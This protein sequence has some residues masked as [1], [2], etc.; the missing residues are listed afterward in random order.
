MDLPRNWE[1]ASPINE[2]LSIELQLVMFDRVRAFLVLHH[3]PASPTVY[4]LLWRYLT[5]NHHAL[6]YDVDVAMA[7]FSFDAAKAAALHKRHC[8]MIAD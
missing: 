3:L 6:A 5:V 1:G 2:T 4:D 7:T 8:G